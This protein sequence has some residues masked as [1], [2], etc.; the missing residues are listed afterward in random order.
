MQ[1]HPWVLLFG[2]DYLG[3]SVL[4]WM[5]PF[6][7]DGP[8]DKGM[9]QFIGRYMSPILGA[10]CVVAAFVKPHDTFSED[11]MVPLVLRI[12]LVVWFLAD[13]FLFIRLRRKRRQRKAAASDAALSDAAF[14][15]TR[16]ER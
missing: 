6:E 8:V 1:F 12:V 11:A 4:S 2:V 10:I 9:S 13:V 16:S 14:M 7:M 5:S 15:T 3:I